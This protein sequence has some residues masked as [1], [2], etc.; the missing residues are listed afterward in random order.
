M[1]VVDDAQVEVALAGV[2]GVLAGAKPGIL[3]V[4]HSTVLLETIKRLAASGEKI[5]V[6]VID[7]P[8]SGGEAGARRKSLCYMVGG[9]PA[10]PERCRKLFSNSAA[11]IFHMGELGCSAAA[12][13]IVQVVTCINMLGAHEAERLAEKS[14]LNFSALQKMLRK[15]SAQSFVVDNW[16]DRFKLADDPMAIRKKR[17][18]V[19]QKG[20]EPA[21]EMAQ[22]LGLSLSGTELVERIL[23][24]IMGIDNE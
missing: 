12:K 6:P 20:L 9:N 13:M 21:L 8:V 23:P 5:G 7:A 19:F 15:S 22:Q 4:I 3:V 11:E 14:S 16:L 10:L 17:T 24:R 2:N 18:A 1:A